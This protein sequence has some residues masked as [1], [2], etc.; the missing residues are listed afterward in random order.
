MK[1]IRGVSPASRKVTVGKTYVHQ[2]LQRHD[3]EIQILRCNLKHAKPKTVP[4]N[5]IWGIDLT[6]KTDAT[7]E[8]AGKAVVTTSTMQLCKPDPGFDRLVGGS[9]ADIV[10]GGNG[11]DVIWGDGGIALNVVEGNDYLDGGAGDDIIL[12]GSGNNTLYGGAG[13][14]TYIFERGSRNVVY[15]DGNNVFRFGDGLEPGAGVGNDRVAA[16]DAIFV[17]MQRKAA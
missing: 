5:L 2:V 14:D 11:D 1:N 9:G 15:D 10:T 13:C 8:G 7:K 16:N 12:G 4:R 3:Y 17:M 6:G